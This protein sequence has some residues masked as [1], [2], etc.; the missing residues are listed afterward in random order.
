MTELAK[1]IPT[2]PLLSDPAFILSLLTVL[3]MLL[4]MAGAWLPV[5]G[6][7]MVTLPSLATVYLAG[8]A[9]WGVAGA[10]GALE[11]SCSGY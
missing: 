5:D 3:G 1:R 10:L 9:S 7:A 2:K 4:G 11:R 8:G 6:L